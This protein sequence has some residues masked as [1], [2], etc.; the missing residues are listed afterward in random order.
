MAESRSRAFD[1]D[2]DE[3]KA[4]DEP[5]TGPRKR[6]RNTT[7]LLPQSNTPVQLRRTV[8]FAPIAPSSRIIVER[9]ASVITPR[10]IAP[11][12]R[13]M[14]DGI[15][16]DF[17]TAMEAVGFDCTEGLSPTASMLQITATNAQ[18]DKMVKYHIVYRH[19]GKY[20]AIFQYKQYDLPVT[21]M[22]E[23]DNIAAINT[24]RMVE[25]ATSVI[26]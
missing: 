2:N 12:S 4:H 1:T 24:A 11:A 3:T 20:T 23:F 15:A 17:M 14:L 19:T 10:V 13:I 25:F 21:T 7:P 26:E 5:E 16:R 6:G 8:R 9:P 18:T 22:F